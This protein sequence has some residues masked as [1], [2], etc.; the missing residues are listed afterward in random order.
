MDKLPEK[1]I[2]YENKITKWFDNYWYYYKW[3]VIIAVFFIFVIIVCTVQACSNT[4]DDVV[5]IY[6][7]E[8]LSTSLEVPNIES[9]LSSVL[10]EDYSGDGKKNVSMSMMTVYSEERIKELEETYKDEGLKISRP[11]NDAELAKF[12]DLIVT[13][14]FNVCLLDPWLYE[15]VK[16]QGGFAKLE[17]TLGYLPDSAVDEYAIK[18][19]DTEFG[20]YFAGVNKL[21][22]DTYLCLRTPGALQS[23][24]GAKSEKFDQAVAFV[25]AIVEFKAPEKN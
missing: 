8:F 16:K 23:M 7:G 17:D 19:S 12:Q 3:K 22:E 4:E 13:G 25:K 2:K 5:I 10:P 9:A 1:K 21:P 15:T 20:R 6:A 14:E 11:N 24:F 18:L